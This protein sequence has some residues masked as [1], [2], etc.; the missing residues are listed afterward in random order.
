[1]IPKRVLEVV[2]AGGGVKS[3]RLIRLT[4]LIVGINDHSSNDP[5]RWTRGLA[6]EAC[7][8]SYLTIMHSTT[9]PLSLY[10]SLLLRTTI[11]HYTCGCYSKAKLYLTDGTTTVAT[12]AMTHHEDDDPFSVVKPQSVNM[13]MSQYIK[14]HKQRRE[15]E[16]C[17]HGTNST[18]STTISNRTDDHLQP[19]VSFNSSMFSGTTSDGSFAHFGEENDDVEEEEEEAEKIAFGSDFGNGLE[20]GANGGKI[21]SSRN[22]KSMGGGRKENSRKPSKETKLLPSSTRDDCMND[23]PFFSSDPF[24]ISNGFIDEVEPTSFG[25]GDFGGKLF[26]DDPFGDCNMDES[27]SRRKRGDFQEI[28]RS[29]SH[30]ENRRRDRAP[31]R[32]HSSDSIDVEG[33]SLTR[34]PV[35]PQSRRKMLAVQGLQGKDTE[36]G[37]P[38]IR[39][40]GG[41][42]RRASLNLS[43]HVRPAKPDDE[44]SLFSTQ[45]EPADLSKPHRRSRRSSL[46]CTRSD[47]SLPGVSNRS[48]AQLPHPPA[49]SSTP[50]QGGAPQRHKSSGGT[51]MDARIGELRMRSRRPGTGNEG[52]SSNLRD[53][54]SDST[55]SARLLPANGPT[56]SDV[57]KNKKWTSD[58]SRNQEMIM[59]MYKEGVSSKRDGQNDFESSSDLAKDMVALDIGEEDLFS[60]TMGDTIGGG[61]KKRRSALSKLKKM[62]KKKDLHAPTEDDDNGGSETRN[63]AG[64]SR[65]T[66]LERVGAIEETSNR[67]ST[68]FRKGNSSYSDRILMSG[69]KK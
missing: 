30:S 23:D 24:G 19:T 61:E 68:S 14:P 5:T 50:S 53:L 28:A 44:E 38:L 48:L 10:R 67:P 43:G 33:I 69:S 59:N 39:S 12:T 21:P 58:R 15:I 63:L 1:V 34:S 62:T 35:K 47:G 26:N 51:S 11:V 60:S 4:D 16:E 31:R 29:S 55:H 52:S 64:R 22:R 36:R 65:G 32:H 9:M 42:A 49:P 18:R 27:G 54:F 25:S 66:L 17:S 57:T 6:Q 7:F 8:V 45:T 3:R 41:T 13:K 40:R 20:F 46:G 56:T 2:V 37:G